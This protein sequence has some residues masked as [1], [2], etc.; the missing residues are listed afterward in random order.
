MTTPDGALPARTDTR[1]WARVRRHVATVFGVGASALMCTAIGGAR[2]SDT[3]HALLP[4]W[5]VAFGVVLGIGAA[6][7]LVWRHDHPQLVTGITL[8]PPV[9]A[10][11]SVSAL[12]AL[13][14]LA[15][16]RR[17]RKLWLATAGVL[18]VTAWTMWL[19][20]Q[21]SVPASLLQEAFGAAPNGP[22]VDVAV[23]ALVLFAA[24]L[25][26][27]PLAVGLLRGTR[28]DLARGAH[29][30]QEL[31]DEVARRDERTRIAREMHDVLGHRLSQL[32]LQA[33]AL[34]AGSGQAPDTADAARTVRTTSR[35][36]LD[37]LRQVIG[38]LRDG[39]GFGA[40]AEPE[41]A[42]VRPQPTLADLPELI[43]STRQSGLAVNATV[44][45][46]D[47]SSAPAQLGTAVY[48]IVQESLTNVLRHASGTAAEVTVRGGP[49]TGLHVDVVNPLPTG[50]AEP[51][52]GSGSGLTGIAERVAAL[53]GTLS[54]GPTEHGTFAV[55]AWLPWPQP[56]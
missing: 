15:A 28:R 52:P 37:D 50:P 17:D 16:A 40:A 48:R 42:P 20:T 54:S 30:E 35:A 23:I 5:L 32:S 53:E 7:A 6:V 36:A 8:V 13:A 2:L 38:V 33:G 26:G 3:G 39:R 22:R 47:A 56:Q 24:L 55:A 4:G 44:L 11:P 25:A 21:R 46:D 19:D 41:P 49:A 1:R 12:V 29:T 9:L 45:L 31:R 14:A 43:T 27:I 51:S 18:A 10:A 34:E